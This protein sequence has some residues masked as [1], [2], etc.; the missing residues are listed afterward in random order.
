MKHDFF[1]AKEVTSYEVA[2]N[3][4]LKNNDDDNYEG[5]NETT[6]PIKKVDKK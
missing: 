1:Q 3:P 4:L 6:Q 2:D 5:D